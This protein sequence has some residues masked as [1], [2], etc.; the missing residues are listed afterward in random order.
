MVSTH[1]AMSTTAFAGVGDWYL[2]PYLL[3]IDKSTHSLM[4]SVPFFGFTTIGAHHSVGCASG[5]YDI[6]LLK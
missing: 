2:L 1:T 5:G 4:S 6:L 3:S